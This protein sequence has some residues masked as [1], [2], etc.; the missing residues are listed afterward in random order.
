VVIHLGSRLRVHHDLSSVCYLLSLHDL[1]QEYCL[2]LG[3]YYCKSVVP[4]TL[5]FRLKCF[6]LH[7]CIPCKCHFLSLILNIYHHI[8]VTFLFPGPTLCI[9]RVD[10][11]TMRRFFTIPPSNRPMSTFSSNMFYFL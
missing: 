11:N 2:R 10:R 3:A 5:Q 7:G 1:L 9:M 8:S 4:P 6:L